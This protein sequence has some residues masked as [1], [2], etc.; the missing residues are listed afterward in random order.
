MRRSRRTRARRAA[1]SAA[2]LGLLG[3]TVAPP[4]ARAVEF[5]PP[6]LQDESSKWLFDT[7]LLVYAESDGRVQLAEPVVS[8]TYDLGDER[9]LSF[10]LVLDTL[11]GAS[12]NGAAPASTPQTFSQP[13]GKGA[14]TTDPG[15]LP[16]DDTFRDTR[17]ALS[18]N[19]LFPVGGDGKLDLGLN[20]S[21]E[22]DFF[23]AGASARYSH[24]LFNGNTT[25]SAG[26]S[27]EADSVDP[28]GG[29]PDAMGPMQPPGAG[30]AA[31]RASSESKNVMDV[32][33]GLTQVIDPESLVQVNYSLSS[34]SGY[35]TDPYKI[36]SVVG[37]DGEPLRYVYESRPDSRTKHALFARYKRFVFARDVVDASYRFMTDDWGVQSNTVDTTYRWN[38][39]ETKYLEP[40]LRW[41]TQTEA[42]FYRVALD[43]GEENTLTEASADPR[44]GAFSG[45]TFGLK[46]GQTL[47]SGNSWSARLEY[48][49]QA[50][51]LAGVPDA[52]AAGLRKFDLE[53]DLSAVMFTVGYRF[54]W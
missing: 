9:A 4:P 5:E 22:F 19:Y 23:S 35:H 14:Y 37:A 54:K 44:L 18:G 21:N 2:T 25:L 39:S 10:K 26:A 15:E 34:S 7:G 31:G 47:K 52:A 3:A 6:S 50:G 38:F 29:V 16:L 36:L 41:Y 30:P 32:V 46:Y 11:T 48:Y 42:D 17:V 43:D 51:Q 1:L 33:L 45:F 8:A 12:P 20:A 13:S 28:V 53:P 24:D 49:Q 40:H 27:F